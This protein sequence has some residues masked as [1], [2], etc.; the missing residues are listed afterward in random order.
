MSKIPTVEI[1]RKIGAPRI[2][3]IADCF[4]SFLEINKEAFASKINF[5]ERGVSDCPLN[6]EAIDWLDNFEKDCL[7]II[8]VA[9]K[10]RKATPQLSLEQAMLKRS[11]YQTEI[12]EQEIKSLLEICNMLLYLG[13]LEMDYDYRVQ[14]ENW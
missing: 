10:R 13:G 3:Y 4:F 8:E 11:H 6:D 14:K 2:H 1:S 5:D 9:Q 7:A 12:N